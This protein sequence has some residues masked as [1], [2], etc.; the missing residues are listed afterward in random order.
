MIKFLMDTL[1]VC[2]C[3][4]AV[5]LFAYILG[6]DANNI[7]GWFALGMAARIKL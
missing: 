4:A 1:M 5:F 3:V 6:E 7:V 2:L